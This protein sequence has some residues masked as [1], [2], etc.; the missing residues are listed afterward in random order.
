MQNEKALFFVILFSCSLAIS[1]ENSERVRSKCGQYL[2]GIIEALQNPKKSEFLVYFPTF[3]GTATTS[4]PVQILGEPI[5]LGNGE[6]RS[7]QL[8]KTGSGWI[9]SDNVIKIVD[10]NLSPVGNFQTYYYYLDN[11]DQPVLVAKAVNNSF[12]YEWIDKTLLEDID[13]WVALFNNLV[14]VEKTQQLF[15]SE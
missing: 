13:A 10:N 1:Q 6:Y 8:R 5:K 15:Y 4:D 9:C 3:S 11:N 12:T 7:W 2:S 14:S